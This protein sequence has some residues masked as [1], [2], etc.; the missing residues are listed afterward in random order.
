MAGPT[1]KTPDGAMPAEDVAEAFSEIDQ[2]IVGLEGQLGPAI[3][4]L[5]KTLERL[6]PPD[7]RSLDERMAAVQAEIEDVP[8]RGHA[9]VTMRGDRGTYSY[10]YVTEADLMIGVRPLLAK[11]GVA[12]YYADEIL[13]YADGSAHVRVTITLAA[14]SESR[15]FTVDGWGNDF[16]DKAANKAKTSALRY[17]LWKTFL[18]PNDE[19]DPEDENV[20][21][22]DAQRAAAQDARARRRRRSTGRSSSSGSGSWRSSGTRSPASRRAARWGDPGSRRRRSSVDDYPAGAASASSSRSGGSSPSTSRTS[23]PG[24]SQDPDAYT[25]A[26]FE[27]RGPQRRDDRRSGRGAVSRPFQRRPTRDRS[28]ATRTLAGRAADGEPPR[29]DRRLRAVESSSRRGS[30]CSPWPTTRTTTARTRTR[31]RDAREEGQGLRADR[32]TRA[33]WAERELEIV[34]VGETSR[35]VR[36]YHMAVVEPFVVPIY[37]GQYDPRTS[38]LLETGSKD[39][40]GDTVSGVGGHPDRGPRTIATLDEWIDRTPKTTRSSTSTSSRSCS[41]GGS[42]A[43]AKSTTAP[44]DA[45]SRRGYPKG[46]TRVKLHGNLYLVGSAALRASR[47]TTGRS[48]TRSRSARSSWASRSTPRDDRRRQG[49]ARRGRRLAG[50]ARRP[51]RS[52]SSSTTRRSAGRAGAARR[53]R[54]GSR[55]RARSSSRARRARPRPTFARRRRLG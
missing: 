23:G 13:S 10:D 38:S 8:R 19:D 16:G 49:H 41:A 52:T 20:A 30:S 54:R 34:D 9:E 22:A 27:L 32:A 1:K 14:G 31:R 37:P 28:T 4:A 43:A 15:V 3:Y 29:D 2:R 55:R 11:H 26:E 36:I 24:R 25:P 33:R 50:R 46:G 39:G 42:S 18:Q 47:S 6:G 21:T 53:E 35:G 17:W 45:G 7:L 40:S 44:S 5:T 48:R 51:S 12:F